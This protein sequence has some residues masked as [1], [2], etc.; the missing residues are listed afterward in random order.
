MLRDAHLLTDVNFQ[1]GEQPQ[2]SHRKKRIATRFGFNF[3]LIPAC[4]HSTAPGLL[5]VVCTSDAMLPRRRRRV[6]SCEFT[7]SFGNCCQL[8]K[9]PLGGLAG[10]EGISLRNF[11]YAVALGTKSARSATTS[12]GIH[13]S[14][15]QPISNRH[16]IARLIVE[17]GR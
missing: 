4:R 3:P 12:C 16:S 6:L 14:K 9:T 8:R 5:R 2:S 11:G 17:F 7:P 15:V 13:I 1:A 10:A